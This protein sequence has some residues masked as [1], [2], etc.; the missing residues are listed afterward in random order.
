MESRPD[1]PIPNGVLD[2]LEYFEFA[3]S[4]QEVIA[5]YD[6]RRYAATSGNIS[7]VNDFCDVMTALSL[8]PEDCQTDPRPAT[9]LYTAFARSDDPYHVECAVK[10]IPK[11]L[12]VDPDGAG[13]LTKECM[14]RPSLTSQDERIHK[15]LVS[16][17][18]KSYQMGRILVRTQTEDGI[19]LLS[20]ERLMRRPDSRA[21]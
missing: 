15:A 19:V 21:S 7:A 5:F 1:Q 2:C 13:R 17:I 8:Y 20:V 12:A 18:D 16:L 6:Q 11:L 9:E 10:L 3:S 4:P 14:L